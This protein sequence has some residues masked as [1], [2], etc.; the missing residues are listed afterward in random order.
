MMY[1]AKDRFLTGHLCVLTE[2]ENS[3]LAECFRLGGVSFEA[4][5]TL[6]EGT[7]FLLAHGLER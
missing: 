2:G 7:D 3:G 4:G 5:V 1:N 6:V